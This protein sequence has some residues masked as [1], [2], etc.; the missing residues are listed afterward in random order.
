M[1]WFLFGF[2][3]VGS[4]VLPWVCLPLFIL[5][6]WL[7]PEKHKGEWTSKGNFTDQFKSDS[8]KKW[9]EL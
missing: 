5:L 3:L 8:S 7:Y 4:F 1:F 9:Y 6:L 2:F